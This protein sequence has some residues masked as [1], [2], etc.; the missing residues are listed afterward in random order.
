MVLDTLTALSHGSK[1]VWERFR[2]S[3]GTILEVSQPPLARLWRPKIGPEVEFGRL[4]RVPSVSRRDPETILSARNCPRS[5]FH[6]FWSIVDRF[7]IDLGS[8]FARPSHSV[9]CFFVARSLSTIDRQNRKK[10]KNELVARAF[11]VWPLELAHTTCTVH[12]TTCKPTLYTFDHA[13]PT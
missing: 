11:C 12:R 9:F 6:G 13:S 8:I 4:G 10:R 7:C 3:P 5:N 2:T 1:V